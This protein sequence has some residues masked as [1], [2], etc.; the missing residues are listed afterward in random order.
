[1]VRPT[2]RRSSSAQQLAALLLSGM[3]HRLWSAARRWVMRALGLK[4]MTVE[5]LKATQRSVH[6]FPEASEAAPTSHND[7]DTL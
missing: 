1:M 4:L 7:G 2:L 6:A 3:P 5:N